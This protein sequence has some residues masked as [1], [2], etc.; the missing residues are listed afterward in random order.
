[1]FNFYKIEIV[2]ENIFD[3]LI[4]NSGPIATINYFRYD[5]QSSLKGTQGGYI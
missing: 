2:I 5:L 4:T 1:M 3:P